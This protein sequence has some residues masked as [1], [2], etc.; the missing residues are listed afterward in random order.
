MNTNGFSLDEIIEHQDFFDSVGLSRH[1]Y[2]DEINNQIFKTSNI[3]NSNQLKDLMDNIRKKEIIQ[4]RCNLIKGYIDNYEE[5]I[6]YM[7]KAIELGIHD[8][9]FVTLTPNNQYCKDHQIDFANLVKL[10]KDL[11]TVNSWN[12]LNDE[13]FSE[14]YCECA[15]YIY[16]NAEGNMCKFYSRLFCR[17]DNNDGILVYDG[18]N[19]RHGFGGRI[20]Y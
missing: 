5:V 9:G 12:R 20:I 8:C 16:S 4:L 2:I 10:S 15:N 6:K 3:A 18:Q 11:I 13:D 17:N 7:D 1:H 14:V 19:L